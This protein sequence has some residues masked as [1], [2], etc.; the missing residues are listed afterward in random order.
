MLGSAC[1]RELMG[2]QPEKQRRCGRARQ[3]KGDITLVFP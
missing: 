1:D 3:F 2:I